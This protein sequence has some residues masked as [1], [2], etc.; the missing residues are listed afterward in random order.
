VTFETDLAELPEIEC[1]PQSLYQVFL[2][3]LVNSEQAIE[4][5]GTVSVRTRLEGE[6]V[7]ASVADTGHGIRPEHRANIFR[8]GFTTKSVGVG[9]GLGLSIC[10]QIVVDRHGGRIEF[11]SEPGVGTTFHVWLPVRQAGKS[12]GETRAASEEF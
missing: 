10:R 2:N 9:S 1:Y 4:G 3:L 6:W 8:P 12:G 5:A 11:E 7:H